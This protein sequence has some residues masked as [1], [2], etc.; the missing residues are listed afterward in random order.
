MKAVKEMKE[1]DVN[2]VREDFSFSKIK[3]ENY[4]NS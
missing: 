2:K 3:G 4:A 1:F